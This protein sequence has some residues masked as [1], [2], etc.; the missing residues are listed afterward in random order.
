MLEGFTDA[1]MAGDVDTRNSTTSYLYTF[2]GAAVSWVSRIQKIVALSKTEAKYI[3]ATE[4]CQDMLW[5]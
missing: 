5:M 1:D 3:T 2:A 4:A